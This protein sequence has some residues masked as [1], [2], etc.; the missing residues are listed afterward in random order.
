M[1]VVKN[2][3][4]SLSG[5]QILKNIGFCL[6]KGEIVALVGPNGAG[7]TTLMRCLSGFYYLDEGEISFYNFSLRRDR[8]SV[9]AK[10]AYVP[11]MGG[12]YPEM[13]V[14]EYLSLMAALRRLSPKDTFDQMLSLVRKL[15]LEFV[16]KQKCETLS[17]GYKK[18]VALAGAML[19]QPDILILDEPTEG[20]DPVQK[21]ELRS[22]L[23]E[24]G[25]DHCILISTHV[26]EEVEA[27]AQRILV[28]SK[29]KLVCDNTPEE[30]KKATAKTDIED[31]FQMIT[32]E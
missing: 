30:L 24:Y 18:R 31:S 16:L 9:L 6:Y 3:S 2:I 27:L 4:K 32:E 17:K 19:S 28:L 13:T 5:K 26:M 22:F 25:K 21:K 12:L 1:L 14:Y 23:K 8:Q 20:L 10:M 7:K 15:N 29:G 11:E